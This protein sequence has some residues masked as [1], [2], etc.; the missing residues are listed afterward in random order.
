[1]P[2][3]THLKVSAVVDHRIVLI[4]FIIVYSVMESYRNKGKPKVILNSD[5]FKLLRSYI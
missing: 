4:I 1:M 3:V 2:I 5:R